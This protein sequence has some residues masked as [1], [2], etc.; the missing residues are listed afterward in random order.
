MVCVSPPQPDDTRIWSYLDG[1]ADLDIRAHIEQCPHCRQRALQLAALQERLLV[2]LYRAVCPT[3]D[4]LGEYHLGVLPTDQASAVTRHLAECSHCAREIAQLQAFLADLSP[5]QEPAS[6]PG[7]LEQ[8]RDRVRT[9][10]AQLSNTGSAFGTIGVPGLRPAMAGIRGQ[11]QMAYCYQAGGIEVVINHQPDYEQPGCR[12]VLGLVIGLES[13]G[14]VATLWQRDQ[15]IATSQ[16]DD[17]DTF[18]LPGVAPGIYELL[19]TGP[20]IEVLIE[21][22]KIEMHHD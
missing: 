6:A 19:F 9:L 14:V 18:Y 3:P 1:E 13:T 11:E 16:V 12:A 22:F 15:Q 4:E 21:D 5:A 2:G 8:V 20:E 7:P 17:L 10:I